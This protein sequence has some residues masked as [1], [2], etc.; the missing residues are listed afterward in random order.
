LT[1]QET[2]NFA[3]ARYKRKDLVSAWKMLRGDVKD[4]LTNFTVKGQIVELTGSPD[5]IEAVRV[6]LVGN[7]FVSTQNSQAV[8]PPLLSDDLCSICFCEVEQPYYYRSCGHGGCSSCLTSQFSQAEMRTDIA[9][10]VVC[11]SGECDHRLLALSDLNALAPPRACAAIK[12]AAVMKFVREHKTSVCICPAPE[13][14]QLL[15]L[16]AV[17]SPTSED[18]EIKLGGTS[19]FCEECNRKVS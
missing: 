5:A 4:D 19:C 7:G 2:V 15:N 10:P 16:E 17:V 3:V 11:F 18:E 1:V 9:V 14:N 13:C 8:N 12:E 6:W